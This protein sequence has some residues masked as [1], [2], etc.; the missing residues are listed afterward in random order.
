MPTLAAYSQGT[1]RKRP[2]DAPAGA[3]P[4]AK[5]AAGRPAPARPAPARRPAPDED[6][7]ES[8][9]GHALLRRAAASPPAKKAA[10]ARGVTASRRDE[11]LAQLRAVEDAIAR[12]KGKLT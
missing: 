11:L 7:G 4:P 5:K 2:A 3:A 10:P 9:E 1:T 8:D 12:K 6:S